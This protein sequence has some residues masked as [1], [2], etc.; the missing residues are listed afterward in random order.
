MSVP[1][2]ERL[3]D[4]TGG[5]RHN[6]VRDLTDSAGILS[7]ESYATPCNVR[8]GDV[9]NAPR[10]S[11]RTCKELQLA[12]RPHDG[13]MARPVSPD[14]NGRILLKRSE[15]A[16]LARVSTETVRR[17]TDTEKVLPVVGSGRASRIDWQD[18]RARAS[19][20]GDPA[21]AHWSWLAADLR[22]PSRGVIGDSLH[23][24]N[25]NVGESQEVERLRTEN[26]KLRAERDT[27]RADAENL[28]QAVMVYRDNWRRHTGPQSPQGL[29]G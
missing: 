16:W 22:H 13:C 3:F 7:H 17:W 15:A 23:V 29:E 5:V 20:A 12:A 26:D 9:A 10:V 27:A 25:A 1:F 8:A 6:A 19:R 24:A 21:P 2:F 18:L 11:L 28:D 14:E 4:G